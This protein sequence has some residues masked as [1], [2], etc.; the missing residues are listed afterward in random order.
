MAENP[1][2][3]INSEKNEEW[4]KSFLSR[5]ENLA[6]INERLIE[7]TL[8]DVKRKSRKYKVLKENLQYI[9]NYAKHLYVNSLTKITTAARTANLLI[10]FADFI[11]EKS[12]RDV[13]RGD[14]ENFFEKYKFKSDAYKAT[15]RRIVKPFFRWLYGYEKKDGYPE[16]VD[17]MYCGRGKNGKLPE[18][19]TMEEVQEMMEACDNLRDRALISVLYESG[20]RAGEILDL[21]IGDLNFD[22]YGAFL[23]V[24]GK[25]GSRRIRLVSSVADLK[26]WLNVHP[27]RGDQ[28]APLFC[29]IT[30]NNKGN[31]LGDSSLSFIIAQIAKRVGIKK[32][33]Y[34]HLFRHTRATHLAKFMTEQEL[35][36]YFGWTQNSHMA[37][38]YVHLSGK[39]IED[40]ILAINGIKPLE[41]G[42]A[43]R[44]PTKRCPRCGEVNSIGNRFCF[45]C[46]NPLDAKTI[47]KIEAIRKIVSDITLHVLKVMEKE[48]VGEKELE[49]V[50][51]EWYSNKES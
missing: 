24:N 2:R 12:F 41:H 15:L 7:I 43:P 14:V 13:E 40:K 4:A 21:R 37:S 1:R 42:E 26:A 35:K 29:S 22:E 18:I 19:L 8:G 47:E 32:R 5:L 38:V 48:R 17:W 34:P 50:V 3:L 31:P 11:R 28:N 27:R 20:C 6:L 30:K 45:K 44:I 49:R 39:D 33:V 23:I 10:Y 46:S 25:T 9:V 51:E 36:V 16:V